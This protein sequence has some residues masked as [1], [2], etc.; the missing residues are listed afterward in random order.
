VEGKRLFEEQKFEQ[1]LKALDKAVS[2]DPQYAMAY[3]LIAENYGYLRDG[4]Q[5]EK[6]LGKAQSLLNRVPEREY[7]M[8]QAFATPSLQESIDLY[9]KVLAIY[10]DD[11]DALGEMG[12]AYR[13]LEKWTLAAQQFEKALGIND[14]DELAYENLAVIYSAQGDYEKAIDLLESK[15]AFFSSWFGFH[16][17]LGTAYL[18]AHRYDR[19]LEEARKAGTVN[20]S[21]FEP[22]ELEGMIHLV[23]GDPAAAERSFRELVRSDNPEFQSTGRGWLC[24]LYLIQGRYGLLREEIRRGLE[25]ARAAEMTQDLRALE[26]YAMKVLSAYVGLQFNDLPLAYEASSQALEAALDEGGPIDHIGPALQ[27]RGLILAKMKRFDEA[28]AAAENLK[29]RIGRSEIQNQL[30]QYHR[31]MGEIAR[32]QGD[33]AKA[34]VSFETAASLLPHQNYKTDIHILYLDSLASAYH[35]RGDLDKARTTYERILSL[36]T[37]RVRWGDLYSKSYYRLGKILQAQGE[38]EKAAGSYRRFLEIWSQADPGLPEVA[39]ARK[40]LAALGA[41]PSS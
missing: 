23:K 14:A 28:L 4:E 18:C 15:L 2:L 41:R 36:T 9:N 22:F 5:F 27:L 39:D 11:T 32:E 6:N 21:D 16:N 35:Q 25:H 26:L 31:L 24:H 19:A 12:A 33:L 34:V 20:P 37:G 38:K 1:S 10:P 7:Y 8:I 13:N 17:R 29:Q 30:R 3:R 40:Q